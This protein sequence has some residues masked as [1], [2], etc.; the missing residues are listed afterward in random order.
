MGKVKQYLL[1]A[2]LCKIYEIFIFQLHGP[3]SSKHTK[4][5]I[6]GSSTITLF[7]LLERTKGNS[8][9]VRETSC[10]PR[11][12]RGRPFKPVQHYFLYP[13]E[14]IITLELYFLCL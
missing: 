10:V 3:Q 6:P 12:D 11:E 7:Y 5:F 9:Y 1:R 13:A 14:H 8:Y 4:S 2:L